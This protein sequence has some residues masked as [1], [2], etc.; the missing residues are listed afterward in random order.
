[1]W[2]YLSVSANHMERREAFHFLKYPTLYSEQSLKVILLI[3]CEIKK[4][5]LLEKTKQFDPAFEQK[6]NPAPTN[7]KQ[8]KQSLLK[9]YTQHLR[10]QI[11]NPA[12]IK[13]FLK[14]DLPRHFPRKPV[15]PEQI[16][17]KLISKDDANET[18]SKV[19]NPANFSFKKMILILNQFQGKLDLGFALLFRV[20]EVQEKILGC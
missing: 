16:T 19:E 3:R 8:I 13:I 10:P 5:L 2:K 18:A 6:H 17:L 7:H 9:L 14:P 12:M 11:R 1:M 4:V 15:K 20:I